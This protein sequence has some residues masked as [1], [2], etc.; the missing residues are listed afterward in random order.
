MKLFFKTILCMFFTC[1]SAI[2]DEVYHNSVDGKAY[3]A[4]E[5]KT[6][7]P[8][9]PRE[10]GVKKVEYSSI[11]LL[12]S[13]QELSVNTSTEELAEYIKVIETE[14]NIA[15]RES[16]SDGIILL[17]IS[18]TPDKEPEYKILYKGNIANEEMQGLYGRLINIDAIK[19]EVSQISFQV[20]LIVN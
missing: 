5:W 20:Q 6:Y 10:M 8:D 15:F 11:R 7:K 12:S 17:Q 16:S 9:N 18:L 14:A 19:V 13:D 1:T 2:A 3:I 4:D